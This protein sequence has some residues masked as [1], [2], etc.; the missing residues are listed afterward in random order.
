MTYIEDIRKAVGDR[1]LLLAGTGLLATDSE[2][3]IFLER[4]SDDGTWGIVGGYLEIGES[5]EEAMRREA[6]EEVGIE[7]GDLRLYGV[8]AGGEYFHEY[9][10]HGRVYSVTIAY[11]ARDVIGGSPADPNEV[12]EVR[13]F[14]PD[15][16]PDNLERTTRLILDQYL[17]VRARSA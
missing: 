1:P 3:R 9:S 12:R 15:E 17:A 2:G 14:A 11:E 5:P 7:L 4:R 16:L 10:G 8:F 13:F 6:Q